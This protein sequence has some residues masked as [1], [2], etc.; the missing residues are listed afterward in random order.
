MKTTAFIFIFSISLV[1]AQDKGQ[2]L[3]QEGKFD[4]AR[5]YYERILRNREKDDAARFGLGT[6][7][8][9]QKDFETAARVFNNVMR[10][11]DKSLQSKALYNIGTLFNEQQKMEESLAFFRKAIES[12]PLN[13]DAKVNYELLKRHL[14]QQQ[15]DQK[16]NSNQNQDSKDQQKNQDNHHQ[17][18]DNQDEEQFGSDEEKDRQKQEQKEDQAQQGDEKNKDQKQKI[19]EQTQE[20]GNDP[21][22]DKQL[23]AEAILN[24]LKDQ[25][26]INQKRQIA[27]AKSRKQEKD[28]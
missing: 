18:K 20:E 22:T 8:Y 10:T 4:E 19:P 12:D 25:E 14:Q 6:S 1:F 27:K 9:Q 17:D 5:A 15:Q 11:K 21:K 13:E 7:A 2:T 3:Y 16:Q 24:A 23:Q 28:W 26:K